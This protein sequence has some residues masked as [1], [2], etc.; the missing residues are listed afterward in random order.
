MNTVLNN[1]LSN[2]VKYCERKPEIN[3]EV[4]LNMKLKI[5]I[6]D[7]GIGISKEDQRHIFDKFYRAG[8]GDFKTVKGLGLGLYYVKQIVTAHHGE[9]F[10]HSLPGKG[11]TFTIEIPLN[12]EHPSG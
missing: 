2:A 6:R 9:I 4:S 1:L 3:V 12:D 5:R 8:K 11:S 10:L 7:N